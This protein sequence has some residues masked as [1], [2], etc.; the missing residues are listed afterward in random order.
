[1]INLKPFT[2]TCALFYRHSHSSARNIQI[3]KNIQH[4]HTNLTHL[5]YLSS[6]VTTLTV[7]STHGCDKRWCLTE[8]Q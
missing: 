3:Y 5:Q 7:I 2:K 8:F 6:N 1:M 4:L